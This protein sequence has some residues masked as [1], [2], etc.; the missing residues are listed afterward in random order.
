MLRQRF[1]IL[2]SGGLKGVAFIGCLKELNR[3]D[4]GGIGGVSVGGLFAML[5]AL[6]LRESELLNFV[7]LLRTCISTSI[8]VRVH[9][10]HTTSLLCIQQ[11]EFMLRCLL[12]DLYGISR[13]TFE[14]FYQR[15]GCVL[16]I[17]VTNLSKMVQE[18]HDYQTTPMNDVIRSVVASCA[19]PVIF[20]PVQIN[21][22]SYCDGAMTNWYPSDLF[23]DS[24]TLLIQLIEAPITGPP[25]VNSI[26]YLLKLMSTVKNLGSV[27]EQL[28]IIRVKVSRV[29]PLFQ[30]DFDVELIREL[31]GDGRR[32]SRDYKYLV[33]FRSHRDWLQLMQLLWNATHD[34]SPSFVISR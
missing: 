21:R 31:L 7:L 5:I 2:S 25:F 32:S 11:L 3:W 8:R 4:W 26:D 27:N 19:V 17:V 13:I 29:I 6:G 33:L 1:L 18:I 10:D 28:S 23:P 12:F 16:K 9:S 14:S 22:D 20:R 24:E 15:T 34:F 30:F